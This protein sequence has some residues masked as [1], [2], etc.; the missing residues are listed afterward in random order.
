MQICCF[1]IPMSLCDV[2]MKTITNQL[3][4]CLGY[5]FQ[6]KNVLIRLKQCHKPSPS[7]HNSQ[8]S[9][10]VTIPS[11]G[12]FISIVFFHITAHLR[13]LTHRQVW[14]ARSSKLSMEGGL[15]Q[16]QQNILLGFMM[17]QCNLMGWKTG[18]NQRFNGIHCDFMLLYMV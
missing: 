14:G 12:W 5:M 10:M 17:C 1:A 2:A 8:K 18:F 3:H 4:R 7:H 16:N 9:G 11:H 13:T 6:T 15:P